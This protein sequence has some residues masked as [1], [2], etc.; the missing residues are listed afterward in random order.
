VEE[1][2]SKIDTAF[3]KVERDLHPCPTTA[4]RAS[5]K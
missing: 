3:R 1:L 2:R 4:S 5:R